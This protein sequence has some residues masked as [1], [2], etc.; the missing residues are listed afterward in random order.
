MQ[1][2]SLTRDETHAEVVELVRCTDC[3]SSAWRLDGAV[4]EKDRALAA[5]SA[6]FTSMAPK[7]RQGRRR[8]DP[9]STIEAP[10]PAVLPGLLAGWRVL[11]S[12]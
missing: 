8:S 10:V 3:G 5:L 1:V 12:S 2:V 6:A 4:V 7:T 11:G 9:G